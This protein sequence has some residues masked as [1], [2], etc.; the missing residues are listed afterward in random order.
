MPEFMQSVAAAFAFALL[1]WWLGTGLIL[2]LVRLK[3]PFAA[4][5][6][7]SAASDAL[8]RVAREEL[9]ALLATEV[10][11]RSRSPAPPAGTPQPVS[12]R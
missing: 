5:Q 4:A 3:A 11:R 9:D 10:A 2:W 7:P 8:R 1:S 6:F 12:P